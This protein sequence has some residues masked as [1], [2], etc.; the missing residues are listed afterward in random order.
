MPSLVQQVKQSYS[1]AIYTFKVLFSMHELECKDDYMISTILIV[2]IMHM[3][4]NHY[5]AKSKERQVIYVGVLSSHV[6]EVKNVQLI[7]KLAKS[8]LI[9]WL[10][11]YVR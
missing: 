3:T 7:S 8:L 6:G 11:E 2:M 4:N 5:L 9:K 10:G 1:D